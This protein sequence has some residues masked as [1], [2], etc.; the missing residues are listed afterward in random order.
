MRRHGWQA[1]RIG[2]FLTNLHRDLHSRVRVPGREAMP[3]RNAK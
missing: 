2:A 3:Y 1:S